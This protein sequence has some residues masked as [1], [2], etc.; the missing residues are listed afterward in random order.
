L[1]S[2]SLAGFGVDELAV[3]AMAGVA[4]EDMKRDALGRRGRGIERDRAGHLAGFEN[5]FPVCARRH[6]PLPRRAEGCLFNPR[7]STRVP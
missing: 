6:D 7:R 4:I 2:N 3:D 1:T 5:T